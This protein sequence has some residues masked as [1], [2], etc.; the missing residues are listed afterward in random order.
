[1]TPRQVCAAFKEQQM[2]AMVCCMQSLT[3]RT[4]QVIQAHSVRLLA[5]SLRASFLLRAPM[6]LRTFL[7]HPSA[8]VMLH[9]RVEVGEVDLDVSRAQRQ[10]HVLALQHAQFACTV[11]GINV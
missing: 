9:K 10:T 8:D 3:H 6:L 7:V 11:C 4:H 5:R 2:Q 1:M